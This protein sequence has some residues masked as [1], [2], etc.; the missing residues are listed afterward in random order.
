MFVEGDVCYK[1]ITLLES[2][3]EQSYCVSSQCAATCCIHGS[4]SF[5]LIH[6]IDHLLR[7]NEPLLDSAYLV[8]EHCS[9]TKYHK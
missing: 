8:F 3:H 2:N 7:L 9:Y 5:V 1:N 6:T 4:R